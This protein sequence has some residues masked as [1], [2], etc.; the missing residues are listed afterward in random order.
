[1]RTSR[2]AILKVLGAFALLLPGVN[3]AQESIQP[4][5]VFDRAEY[6]PGEAILFKAGRKTATQVAP[7]TLMALACEI[8]VRGSDGSPL[9]S[10]TDGAGTMTTYNGPSRVD[11][12]YNVYFLNDLIEVKPGS[13]QIRNTCGNQTQLRD[14]AVKES[15]ALKNIQVALNFPDVLDRTGNT[16]L[17]IDFKITNGQNQ[18]IHLVQPVSNYRD[19]PQNH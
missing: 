8:S 6:A 11:A 14:I 10:K 12:L 4:T 18:R 3:W 17:K 19:N 15:P 16:P 9:F 7:Y 1:M 2:M 13:Y 5:L